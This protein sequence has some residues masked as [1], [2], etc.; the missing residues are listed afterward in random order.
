MRPSRVRN[1]GSWLVLQG[2][3]VKTCM[4]ETR[5]LSGKMWRDHMKEAALAEEGSL[6]NSACYY[7]RRG[8]TRSLKNTQTVFSQWR[9][10]PPGRG[11]KENRSTCVG[12]LSG[13][14]PPAPLM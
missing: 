8:L 1:D 10:G 11:P 12:T 13:R 6:P 5:L 7:Y 9:S 14:R 3:G 4:G 2:H